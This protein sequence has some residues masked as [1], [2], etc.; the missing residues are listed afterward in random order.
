MAGRSC[1]DINEFTGPNS[2]GWRYLD[3]WTPD[4]SANSTAGRKWVPMRILR[5]TVRLTALVVI[6][7]GPIAAGYWHIHFAGVATGIGQGDGREV[8]GRTYLARRSPV[9]DRL[10]PAG[11]GGTHFFDRL[12]HDLGLAFPNSA[13]IAL[14]TDNAFS[15]WPESVELHERAHLVDA[16]L[17]REVGEL[18]ARLPAPNPDEYA[19]T[20]R[21]EHFAEMAARAWEIV[22][23]PD[24]VCVDGTPAD[25]L[26]DADQ[27]VPGTSGF[28]EWYLRHLPADFEGRDDLAALAAKLRAPLAPQWDAL[29][30]AIE[31]RREPG[32]GFTP[33]RPRTVRQFIE[34]QRA[35]ALASGRWID[36]VTG[37]L[38]VPSLL[39]LSAVGQ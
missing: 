21:G 30:Q 9:I 32:G 34:A 20:D 23:P 6:L 31:A 5:F 11:A 12:G 22:K 13:A 39:V 38:L 36:R 14:V 24:D 8:G 1:N 35:D 4:M 19:A 7:F 3:T 2:A 27:R 28:V 10:L 18:M 37:A 16:S 15:A 25:R 33:W 29:W 17:P 26:R